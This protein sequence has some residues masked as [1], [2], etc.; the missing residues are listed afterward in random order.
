MK[1]PINDIDGIKER[2]FPTPAWKER[3]EEVRTM[4]VDK[5]G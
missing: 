3:A 4:L 2:Y 5:K 1:I